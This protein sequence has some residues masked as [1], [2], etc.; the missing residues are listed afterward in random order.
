MREGNESEAKLLSFKTLAVIICNHK[1]VF[2]REEGNGD[3]QTSRFD[4]N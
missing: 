3:S 2:K 4:V 1:G